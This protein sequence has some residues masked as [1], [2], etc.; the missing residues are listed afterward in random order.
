[1]AAQAGDQDAL[2]RIWISAWETARRVALSYCKKY[3]WLDADDLRGELL[4]GLPRF[5][6]R[7]DASDPSKT[8]WPKY[9]FFKMNFYAKDVLRREDPLGISW[10]Q[11]RE[12][13]SWN[14]LGDA[15]LAG[16][17]AIDSSESE[18]DIID[19]SEVDQVDQLPEL[20]SL[21]VEIAPQMFGLG[22]KIFMNEY[23]KKR[24]EKNGKPVKR[25]R[26]KR[27]HRPEKVK[28]K[29]QKSSFKNYVRSKRYEMRDATEMSNSIVGGQPATDNQYHQ[30]PAEPTGS[31]V[32]PIRR[33][34]QPVASPAVVPQPLAE[35]EPQATPE[36]AP[37]E[38]APE[39]APEPEPAPAAKKKDGWTPA[40]RKRWLEDKAAAAASNSRPLSRK[41]PAKKSSKAPQ[42]VSAAAS[43]TSLLSLA[44]AFVDAAGGTRNARELLEQIEAMKR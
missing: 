17:D 28:A 6:K 44:A 30:P 13:P 37:P 29:N 35:P 3:E 42:Q 39:A 15:S 41:A 5:I 4:L 36:A 27:P 21:L 32:A 11:K 23:R 14:R 7:Y 33:P 10:P 40:K 25:K 19:G 2:D 43:A 26:P 8:D 12:Y 1:M 18:I 22:G 31:I 16:F 38:A 9:L 34:V 20:R 24:L